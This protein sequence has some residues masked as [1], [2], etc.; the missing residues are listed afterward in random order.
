MTRI[1]WADVNDQAARV[2]AAR[3]DRA[4]ETQDDADGRRRERPHQDDP[5]DPHW[6]GADRQ[7][8]QSRGCGTIPIL[9]TC[10][11]RPGRR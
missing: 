10:R 3:R 8:R 1:G 4:G 2:E 7:S 6:G 9:T 11:R 5:D